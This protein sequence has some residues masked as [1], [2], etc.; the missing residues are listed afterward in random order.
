MNEGRE[1]RGVLGDGQ[2]VVL[3]PML[4]LLLQV[5]L[6]ADGAAAAAKGSW[7]P[8]RPTGQRVNPLPRPSP[9]VIG[10]MHAH[11]KQPLVC[12][13][14]L[15]HTCFCRTKAPTRTH[16]C[17]SPF[18]TSH[19]C[20]SSLLQV[21]CQPFPANSNSA[22]G[23]SHIWADLCIGHGMQGVVFQA[24]SHTQGC[25]ELLGTQ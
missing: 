8:H 22:R 16:G 24:N 11:H 1:K 21:Q 25:A 3:M 20:C 7:L 12:S 14:P 9:H 15:Q 4:P 23:A 10:S 18:S 2:V 19:N 13:S 5:T 6:T 17:N